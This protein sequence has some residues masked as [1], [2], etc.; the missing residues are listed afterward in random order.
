MH[1]PSEATS[2]LLQKYP[3]LHP[4]TLRIICAI[5]YL[6]HSATNPMHFAHNQ[7]EHLILMTPA[8]LQP[9]FCCYSRPGSGSK[10]GLSAHVPHPQILALVTSCWQIAT[11]DSI[12]W[13]LHRIPGVCA[14]PMRSHL[15]ASEHGRIKSPPAFKQRSEHELAGHEQSYTVQDDC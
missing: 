12:I 3:L 2:Y 13:P 4:A 9:R 5:I 15:T 10:L 7:I 8:K 1:S 6:N 11:S 14:E